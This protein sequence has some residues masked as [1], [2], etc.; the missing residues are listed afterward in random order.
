[1][2]DSARSGLSRFTV[3]QW[4]GTAMAALAV[5]AVAGTAIALVALKRNA[6]ARARV[7]GRVDPALLATFRLQT[8]LLD[9][10]T[11]VR[12][13]VLTG[14]EPFL[15][16]YTN[17]TRIERAAFADLDRLAALGGGGRLRQDLDRV[18]G[19][20]AAWR[21]DYADV[22]V[23][24][25]RRGDRRAIDDALDAMGK[26]RFDAIRASL[27]VLN[28]NL[29]AERRDAR[30]DLT[31]AA[32]LVLVWVVIAGVILV[33]ALIAAT[34]GLRRVVV[35]PLTALGRDVRGVAAGAFDHR[36][37]VDGPRE[38]ADL[39]TDV[40]AMRR[41][42][43]RE[44]AALAAA[45]DEL[46]TRAQELQSSNAELEQF[47]YVASHDLQEPLRKVAS[48]CQMLERR[49]EDQLDD[50]G[51]EYIA[52]A[53]DGAKRMQ[54]LINDLLAFSRV[55]R[56]AAEQ[57]DVDL[58][59]LVE[60]VR[61]DLGEAIEGTRACI[62]VGALPAVRGDPSLLSVVFRNLIANAI[63][64]HGDDPPQVA[65]SA[66]R[67]GESWEFT[68]AD[69]GI[70]IEPEYAERIFVIFQRLHTRTVYP[71]TGIGL[72]ITRKIV[73]YHGGRIWLE[74]HAAGAG[75]TFRF[76]LPSDAQEAPTA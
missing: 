39:G 34:L 16:P 71:G 62:E 73:E 66:R 22:A 25:L 1:M 43:L 68:V 49:Y 36:L 2:T 41:R 17:G 65:V 61:R 55:G 60:G 19:S 38:I 40:D 37:A 21:N 30:A 4:F 6:D 75:A 42:I 27:A 52:Y 12:G 50:R 8:A 23:A 72:A 44:V 26:S 57:D 11:G 69:N 10:E 70:G 74:P 32:R 54:D 59:V 20:A 33:L 56:L 64:F 47:A 18:R 3:M 46:A 15:A 9:E 14:Q 48:F 35:Q 29:A 67:D 51:R 76:T 58:E 31:S 63:K 24:A 5:V 13:Y 45:R 53:V 7:V 28:A